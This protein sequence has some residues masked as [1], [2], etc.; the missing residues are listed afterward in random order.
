MLRNQR[1]DSLTN[2]NEEQPIRVARGLPFRRF[3]LEVRPGPAQHFAKC[4]AL[5]GIDKAL[6]SLQLADTLWSSRILLLEVAK[7]EPRV[8]SHGKIKGALSLIG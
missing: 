5:F 2:L 3:D 1:R 6:L 4:T 8:M 7:K